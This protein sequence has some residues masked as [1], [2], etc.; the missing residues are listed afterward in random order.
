MSHSDLH[1]GDSPAYSTALLGYLGDQD[2]M[3]VFAATEAA[4][5]KATAG[6]SEKR[7]RTP[8][9]PGKWSVIEVVQHLADAEIMLAQRYRAVISEENPVIEGRDQDAWAKA[10]RYNDANLEVALD[11]FHAIRKCNLRILRDTSPEERKTKFGTHNQRG[12]E[13]LDHVMRLYAAHD[14]YHL[15]QIERIKKAVGADQD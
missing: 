1:A 4:L 15:H 3:E 5:R 6:L 10:L 9:A 13:T 12:R 8:E 11:Q 14:L 7:L 2:P